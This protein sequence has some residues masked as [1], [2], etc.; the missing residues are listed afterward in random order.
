[1]IEVST[2]L[3]NSE[4]NNSIPNHTAS[5]GSI[6]PS[7]GSNDISTEMAYKPDKPN[8]ERLGSPQTTIE[9]NSKK[10][11]DNGDDTYNLCWKEFASNLGAF[12][13]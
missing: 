7:F 5:T 10:I 12:F 6:S 13:R 11:S 9:K 1:M 8:T 4:M 3:G 2:M